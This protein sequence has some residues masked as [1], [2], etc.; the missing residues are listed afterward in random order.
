MNITT[1]R[2]ELRSLR[3][4]D[5]PSEY[6]LWIQDPEITR[7]LTIYGHRFDEQSAREYIDSHKQP[8]DA[9]FGIYSN[10]EKMIGTHSLRFSPVTLRGAIGG[11]I[12]DK[13]Y[14]GTNVILETRAALLS[15]MFHDTNCRKIEAGCYKGNIPAIYNFARQNWVREGALEAHRTINGMSE[16]L[17]LFGMLRENWRGQ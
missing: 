7:Y 13:G 11:M 9:F 14:W 15:Y 1:E 3:S 4:N 2:F 12:G 16:D 17:I 5:L 6:F 10:E 8:N